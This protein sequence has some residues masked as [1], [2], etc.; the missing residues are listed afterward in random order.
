MHTAWQYLTVAGAAFTAG[1]LNA[2]A[3]GGTLVS[4][5]ALLGIGLTGQQANVTSTL[6]LWPGSV[7][8]FI[9]H[10]GDLKG[11]RSFALRLMPPSLGGA[12][13]GAGLML[14]TPASTFNLLIPWLI[15]TATLL[16]AA[17]D[18][19]QRFLGAH[20]GGERS[21]A[22]W[23]GAV[24][25]QFLVG[26]YGGF[27]G[28][29]IGILMLAALSLL[30]LSDIHQ[31]NGLKN[32][33]SLSINGIAILCFLAGEAVFRAHNIVWSAAAV[34]AA[35]AMAGGLF[36]SHMAHRVG[37]RTVRVIV[38]LVGFVLTAWYFHKV[39]G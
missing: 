16:M 6:A 2:I 3:G 12:L 23:V 17:N 13:V 7:G 37:R 11:T 35:A 22:W 36:G 8:G 10:R 21:R 28:A 27:F 1:T 9:G 24:G 39:H 26:V 5:P 33:L 4:F 29:G 19:I 25:F 32:F 30:G 31:M 14:A 18:P 15:L 38:I 20:P 34:M